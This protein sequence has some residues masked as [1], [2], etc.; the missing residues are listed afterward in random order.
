MVFG[1]FAC[2][3]PW[4]HKVVHCLLGL[5]NKKDTQGDRHTAAA[6][7]GNPESRNLVV[8]FF[9]E[10]GKCGV[11]KTNQRYRMIKASVSPPP[12][13]SPPITTF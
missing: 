6:G 9:F 5:D 11:D 8:D 4:F 3:V 13:E 10:N 12:A 7:S 2:C 1:L